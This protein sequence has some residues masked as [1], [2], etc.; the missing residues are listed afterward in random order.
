LGN[1]SYAWKDYIESG[2]HA[3][4]GTDCPVEGLNPMRG[5]YCAV[6]GCDTK[7]NG[8]AWPQQ[9]LSREQA[10]FGYT[11]AGAYASFDENVKGMIKPGMYADFIVVDRDL[12]TCADHEILDAKVISTYI[13]GKKVFER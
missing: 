5:I 2:V 1:T 12:M 4:F 3:P 8:P 13:N 6:T 7:G 10:L 11:A 9:I